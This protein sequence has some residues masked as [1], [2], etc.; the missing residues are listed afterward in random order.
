MYFLVFETTLLSKLSVVVEMNKYSV[1]T[2]FK[3]IVRKTLQSSMYLC[4]SSTYYNV[5]FQ[6]T[7]EGRVYFC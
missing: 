7:M 2:L 5:M 6:N 1:E 3:S 4:V